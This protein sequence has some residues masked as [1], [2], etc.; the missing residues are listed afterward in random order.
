MTLVLII[1]ILCLFFFL[2]RQIK[3]KRAIKKLPK[4]VKVKQHQINP[5]SRRRIIKPVPKPEMSAKNKWLHPEDDLGE[6]ERGKA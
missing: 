2:V 1:V 3:L 6:F 4:S 5:A